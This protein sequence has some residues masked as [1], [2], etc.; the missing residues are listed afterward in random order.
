MQ[1][2]RFDLVKIAIFDPVAENRNA[3]RNA[4]YALGFRDVS[5][6]GSLSA[7][8]EGFDQQEFDAIILEVTNG[9]SDLCFDFVAAVRHGEIG[10]NPFVV[11]SITTFLSDAGIVSRALNAGA[12]DFVLRPLALATLEERVMAVSRHRKPFVVTADYIG[13][14]RRSGT[15]RP[16]QGSV[17]PFEVANSIWLKAVYGVAGN[18]AKAAM[19]HAINYSRELVRRERLLRSSM[20][21]CV[22]LRLLVDQHAKGDK[23]RLEIEDSIKH[24]AV[25]SKLARD[26]Q[27]DISQRAR[28]VSEIIKKYK[29][30]NGLSGV[31]RSAY[32]N[33]CMLYGLLNGGMT[34]VDCDREVA[35]T[36]QAFLSRA[37]VFQPAR[38]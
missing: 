36:V 25:I 13:P 10:N 1:T 6:F 38:V 12:D 3:S 5:T 27:A 28:E 7:L 21:V 31:L 26:N 37:L 4:F 34:Q 20:R 32:E 29:E 16:A 8:R 15:G 14:D 9:V 30:N 23:A 11:I 33:A 24:C 35:G 18:E 22:G 19:D 17:K 2:L